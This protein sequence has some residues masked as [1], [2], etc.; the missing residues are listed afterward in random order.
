MEYIGNENMIRGIT[1]ILFD[2]KEEAEGFS[3]EQSFRFYTENAKTELGVQG[4]LCCD[5]F[6]PENEDGSSTN[7]VLWAIV[8]NVTKATK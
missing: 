1:P 8:I 2:S 5:P 6:H 4:V 3:E 7:R